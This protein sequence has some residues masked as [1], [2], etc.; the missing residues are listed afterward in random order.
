MNAIVPD[1]SVSQGRQFANEHVYQNIK[2]KVGVLS[3]SERTHARVSYLKSSNHHETPADVSSALRRVRNS[4]T[5]PP[6]KK[7]QKNWSSFYY[8]GFV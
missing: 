4:G 2:P 3:S 1:I 6:K 8:Q 5:V 7:S